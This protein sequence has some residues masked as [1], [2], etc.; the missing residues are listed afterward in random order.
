MA[1]LPLLRFRHT[2]LAFQRVRAGA[3]LH[4]PVLLQIRWP[5]RWQPLTHLS[6]HHDHPEHDHHHD[7]P[8]GLH[9]PHASLEC[10]RHLLWLARSEAIFCAT[11]AFSTRLKSFTRPLHVSPSGGSSGSACR[12]CFERCWRESIDRE[13]HRSKA[14][15]GGSAPAR[16]TSVESRR[17]SFL[18]ALYRCNSTAGLGWWRRDDCARRSRYGACDLRWVGSGQA[19]L[20]PYKDTASF[21]VGFERAE[22]SK[23]I[24]A[25][26][27][28]CSQSNGRVAAAA[29]AA[30]HLH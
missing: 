8:L 13:T 23:T 19:G 22:S 28:G 5:H 11:S 3:W 20:W 15:T 6:C 27:L 16:E 9:A 12:D 25:Q 1:S 21:M 30:A 29:A 24:L 2:A 7:R 17:R 4:A 14:R 10:V 18:V 26:A